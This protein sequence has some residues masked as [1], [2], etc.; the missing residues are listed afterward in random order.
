MTTNPNEHM[1]PSGV[2][3]HILH[4]KEL[5]DMKIK[6]MEINDNFMDQSSVVMEAI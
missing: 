2:P 3:N 1:T 4:L 5:I 6:I